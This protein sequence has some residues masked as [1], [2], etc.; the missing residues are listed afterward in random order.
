MQNNSAYNEIFLLDFCRFG[1]CGCTFCIHWN[2]NGT[3]RPDCTKILN[4]KHFHTFWPFRLPGTISGFTVVIWLFLTMLLLL[5]TD[6]NA[7]YGFVFF[8]ISFSALFYSRI[9]FLC[10]TSYMSNNIRVISSEWDSGRRVGKL[11][12]PC[13][14]LTALAWLLSVEYLKDQLLRE[15]AQNVS[16]DEEQFV[17]MLRVLSKI[18]FGSYAEI[19]EIDFPTW[20][21]ELVVILKMY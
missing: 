1:F 13:C 17:R 10:T 9:G 8:S 6:K 16:D 18:Q 19:F 12:Y 20:L 7:C 3:W 11:R 15:I 4:T 5:E 21:D 14:L 2:K